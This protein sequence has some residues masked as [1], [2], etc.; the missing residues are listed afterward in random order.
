M[1][2]TFVSLVLFVAVMGLATA[3]AANGPAERITE[4]VTGDQIFCDDAAYTVTPERS[5][6]SPMRARRRRA[7]KTSPSR[8]RR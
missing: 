5:G 3:A 6:S 4:D 7:T 1:R 8:S 2:K